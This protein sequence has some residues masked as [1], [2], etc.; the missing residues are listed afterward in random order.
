MDSVALLKKS[1]DAVPVVQAASSTLSKDINTLKNNQMKISGAA[2]PIP[3]DQMKCNIL[4]AKMEEENKKGNLP[5]CNYHF[6]S[7]KNCGFWLFSR[8]RRIISFN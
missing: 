4:K 2:K 5:V 8:E 7:W 6:S 1:V 3:A